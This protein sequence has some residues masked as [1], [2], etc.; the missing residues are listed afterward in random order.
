MDWLQIIVAML[1]S[2]VLIY[3]CWFIFILITD[4]Y[5]LVELNRSNSGKGLKDRIETTHLFTGIGLGILAMGSLAFSLLGWM[6]D[7]WGRVD[8][9]GEWAS[10]RYL[11][12]YSFAITGGVC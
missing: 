2:A 5:R 9:Y 11:L 12:S 7:N 4:P 8:E 3:S 1:S 10:Y 6:P